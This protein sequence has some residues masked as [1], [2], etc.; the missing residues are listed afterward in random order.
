MFPAV[1]KYID[2]QIQK[3]FLI[4]KAPLSADVLLRVQRG[5]L[6]STAIPKKYKRYFEKY[7]KKI[8]I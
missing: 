7:S 5:S 3:G 1:E 6:V 4:S 8:N 2:S